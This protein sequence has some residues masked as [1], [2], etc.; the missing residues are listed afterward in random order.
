MKKQNSNSLKQ[1]SKEVVMQ[2]GCPNCLKRSSGN[3]GNNGSNGIVKAE[4]GFEKSDNTYAQRHSKVSE[5]FEKLKSVVL[6]DT[7]KSRNGLSKLSK[8]AGMGVQWFCCI[9]VRPG[10]HIPELPE[11]PGFPDYEDFPDG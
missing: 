3:D 2:K 6:N 9:A 4:A 5:L 10:R 1:V 11:L 7:L 8:M